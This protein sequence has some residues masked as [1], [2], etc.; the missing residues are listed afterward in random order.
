[1]RTVP[2]KTTKGNHDVFFKYKDQLGNWR[3]T[4]KRNLNTKKEARQYVRDY[5]AAKEHSLEMTL[6]DFYEQVYKRDKY[7]SLKESTKQTKD[8]II[9]THILPALGDKRMCDIKPVDVLHFFNALGEQDYSETFL[10][11]IRNQLSAMMN[12]AVNYYDL[13]SNPVRKVGA[14]GSKKPERERP[15]W[16]QDQ[17]EAFL[18]T[19]MDK[20][21]VYLAFLV[22]YW[23]GLRC[24]ELLSLR[25]MDIDHERGLIM[26]R[27]TYQ[28]IKGKDVFT[29]PKTANSVRDVTM[30]DFLE[31][32]IAEHIETFEVAPD[33]RIFD[34]TKHKLAHEMK[35][36]C[37]KHG[38]EP[39]P[40][41]SL[42]HSHVALL[43]AAGV[44][45]TEVSARLGHSASETTELYLHF[46]DSSQKN[47]AD[48]LNQIGGHHE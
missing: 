27:R 24:G 29:T 3:S 45:L 5:I 38:V 14:F 46:F 15:F 41:H 42:R 47:I 9:R 28:R 44:P 7:P 10:R 35:R 4:C 2:N 34:F 33:Q 30:P 26:V 16:N 48:K 43:A 40:I 37:A 20:P 18:E 6:R 8:N 36:G 12:H 21:D 17:M 13:N 31:E 25:P 22:L 19:V 32:A 1:M 39:I 23:C 11:T